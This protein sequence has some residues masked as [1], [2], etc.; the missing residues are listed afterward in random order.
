[1]DLHGVD[2]VV[3]AD[4]VSQTHADPEC[5]KESPQEDDPKDTTAGTKVVKEIDVFFRTVDTK[6]QLHLLQ[7]PPYVQPDQFD[8]RCQEVLLLISLHFFG[9]VE[10]YC[11]AF[12]FRRSG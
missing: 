11:S 6:T 12:D 5:V 2:E 8:E 4:P 9:G 1:M 10:S 3:G 7:C